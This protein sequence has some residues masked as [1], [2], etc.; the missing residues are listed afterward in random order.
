MRR[1]KRIIYLQ[2][3]SR[4]EKQRW[5]TIKKKK[6]KKGNFCR[7]F[8]R[9]EMEERHPHVKYSLRVFIRN[10]DEIPAQR[11]IDAIFLR[12]AAFRA[13]AD[14]TFVLSAIRRESGTPGELISRLSAVLTS[15]YLSRFSA[16]KYTFLL[17]QLNFH[18]SWRR[19]LCDTREIRK[20]RRLFLKNYHSE[21]PKLWRI[22]ISVFK[23]AFNTFSRK[24]H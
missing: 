1:W 14:R 11:I 16:S 24:T 19:N 5:K 8:Y 9:V 10:P 13:S 20:L 7:F 17:L 18:V 12:R 6:K 22:N 23:S 4:R 3:F 2:Y 21:M 15:A